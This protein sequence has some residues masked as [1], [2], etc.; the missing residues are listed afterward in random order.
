MDL[1]SCYRVQ[2]N[3]IMIECVESWAFRSGYRDT[4]AIVVLIL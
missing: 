1:F 2:Q 3:T 4:Y